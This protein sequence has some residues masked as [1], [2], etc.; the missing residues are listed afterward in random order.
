MGENRLSSFGLTN[1]AYIN[2]RT[3][4]YQLSISAVIDPRSVLA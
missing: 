3:V 1:G 4:I 2:T